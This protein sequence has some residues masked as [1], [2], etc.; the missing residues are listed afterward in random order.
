MAVTSV[1]RF[2]FEGLLGGRIGI[3][4]AGTGPLRA[5][6]DPLEVV[7]A[8]LG[9]DGVPAGL[10]GD[11]AG[12]IRAGPQPSVRCWAVDGRGQ[13]LLL[14]GGEQRWPLGRDQL[15][16]MVPEARWSFAVIAPNDAASV[17]FLQADQ[18]CRI[19][20]G[21][22]IGDQCQQLPAPGFHQGRGVAGPLAQLIRW[23][24]WVEVGSACHAAA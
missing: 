20:G 21:L 16:S 2:F 6:P 13:L 19:L 12:H 18:C 8:A 10:G 9:S 14:L 3:R 15:E 17:V 23:Q 4:V 24:V 7:M 1:P 5:H 22:A 11:P